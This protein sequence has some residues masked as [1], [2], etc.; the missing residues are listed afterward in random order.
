M[1]DIEK[2]YGTTS[3]MI[4]KG[5]SEVLQ[6]AE[7]LLEWLLNS[8]GIAL[9]EIVS[10]IS[11]CLSKYTFCFY[12]FEHTLCIVIVKNILVHCFIFR[13][14][15]FLDYWFFFFFFF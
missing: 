3:Y 1:E 4:S 7:K 14:R 13:T 9:M 5:V 12:T 15:N 2:Y 6:S 8:K 10:L 11:F